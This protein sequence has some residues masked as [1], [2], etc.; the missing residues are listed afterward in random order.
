MNTP[1]SPRSARLA[2]AA[3]HLVTTGH[4]LA[5]DM[6]RAEVGRRVGS[7]IGR[8]PDVGPESDVG[9]GSDVG[10]MESSHGQ[11]PGCDAWPIQVVLRELDLVTP[12]LTNLLVRSAAIR[13]FDPARDYRD[14]AGI[15][16]Q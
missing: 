8:E 7:D 11:S 12:F 15:T 13:P 5:V 1:P 10:R 6:G 3:G 14:D 9:S 4:L 2:R 16:F